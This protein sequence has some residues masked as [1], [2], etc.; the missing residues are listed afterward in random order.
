MTRSN[1]RENG[2]ELSVRRSRFGVLRFSAVEMLIAL[3]LLFVATPFI[4]S[5]PG[6]DLIEAALMSLFFLSAVLAVGGRR[7]MLV[8]TILLSLPAVV[9][10]WLH[11][12]QPHAHSPVLFLVSAIVFLAFIVIQVLRFVLTAKRVNAEVLCASISAYLTMGLIW[13]MAYRL[14]ATFS[15]TAFAFSSP[16]AANR[17]MEGFTAFYFSFV[18]LSTVGYGDITPVSSVAR[19]LAVLESMTGTLYVA[20]LIARLVALYSTPEPTN[21]FEPPQS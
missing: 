2:T 1:K 20:V 6:G 3:V 19:M 21:Q 9:G 16:E 7:G 12:L 8:L 13:A 14:V 10:K 17:P 15:A 11:H 4:E 18:T 5:L